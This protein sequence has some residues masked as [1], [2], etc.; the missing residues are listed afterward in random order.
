MCKEVENYIEKIPRSEL[1]QQLDYALCK[2]HLR[3]MIEDIAQKDAD[4]D[5]VERLK[6]ITP[7]KVCDI[8]RELGWEKDTE[9]WF[10]NGWEQDTWLVFYNK[11]WCFRLTLFYSGYN[12]TMRLHRYMEDEE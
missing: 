2:M 10:S 5:V 7:S 12:W 6:G 4:I 8:L 9:E 3:L 1:Y 11:D